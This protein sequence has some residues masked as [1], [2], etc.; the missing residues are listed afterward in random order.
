MKINQVIA[1]AFARKEEK[2]KKGEERQGQN[3]KAVL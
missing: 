3:E 2:R 1:A